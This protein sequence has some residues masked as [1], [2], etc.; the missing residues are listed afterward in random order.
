MRAVIPEIDPA[1]CDG[2]GDCIE[3][4]ASGAFTLVNGKVTIVR[5]EDCDYCTD[6]ETSCSSGAIRCAFEIILEVES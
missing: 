6:C 2:C 4:C 1:K 3:Q 5:S